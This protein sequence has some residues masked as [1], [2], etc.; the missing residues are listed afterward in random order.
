MALDEAPN[1]ETGA[2]NTPTVRTRSANRIDH[3]K[4]L[5]DFYNGDQ[6]F[7]H[8]VLQQDAED[9]SANL[10]PFLV[11]VETRCNSYKN[12]KRVSDTWVNQLEQDQAKMDSLLSVFVKAVNACV[13]FDLAFKKGA[14]VDAFKLKMTTARD[15]VTRCNKMITETLAACESVLAEYYAPP[16]FQPS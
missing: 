10:K 4:I 14:N 16:S 13:S 5:N 7:Y 6:A 11:H 1:A 2:V 12:A 9:A 15:G 8:N 3:Q